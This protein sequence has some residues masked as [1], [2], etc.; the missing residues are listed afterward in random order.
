M[1]I[2]YSVKNMAI[3]DSGDKRKIGAQ[4]HVAT[5]CKLQNNLRPNF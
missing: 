3:L 2:E 1:V 4:K 5:F